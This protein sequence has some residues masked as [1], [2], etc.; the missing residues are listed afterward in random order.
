M[1]RRNARITDAD[2]GKLIRAYENGKALVVAADI[3]GIKAKTARSIINTYN[4]Q[5]RRQKL[6]CGGKRPK[7][8]SAEM[9]DLFSSGDREFTYVD[10]NPTT[11]VAFRF[12][13]LLI[14]CRAS[15]SFSNRSLKVLK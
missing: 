14:I 2:R 6:P 1:Q 10:F 11:A 15:S 5:G 13:D 9:L 12:F 3:L 4:Q 8:L 7:L